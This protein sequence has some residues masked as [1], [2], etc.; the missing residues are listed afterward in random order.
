MTWN[1]PRC[2]E[3][4]GELNGWCEYCKSS[5]NIIVYN[6]DKYY[7]REIRINHVIENIK[8]DTTVTPQEELF[9]ELFNHEKSLVKDMDVLTLR[10]HREELSKIAF[11]ARARLTA[12]DD[13]ENDR[14]KLARPK[15]AQGFERSINTDETTTNAIS[16]IQARQ[17]KL[18]KKEQVLAGLKKLYAMT[19]SDDAMKL[20]E[21]AMKNKNILNSLN[22]DKAEGV[23][24]HGPVGTGIEKGF[25]IKTKPEEIKRAFDPFKKKE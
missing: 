19:G 15:G 18:S 13:E 14:K 24:A 8:G 2:S 1:C 9:A 22:Q 25:V 11:E 6:P 23:A 10:A 16:V 21:E 7:I 12:V 5:D 17:T 3:E 4:L 20:A